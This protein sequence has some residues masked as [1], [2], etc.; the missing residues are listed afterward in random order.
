MCECE[1]GQCPQR[2]VFFPF[3]LWQVDVLRPCWNPLWRFVRYSH[4]AVKLHDQVMDFW[5]AWGIMSGELCWQIVEMGARIPLRGRISDCNLLVVYMVSG[6]QSCI[7]RLWISITGACNFFWQSCT[8]R[9]RI[10]VN[11]VA[12]LIFGAIRRSDGM[13]DW[14][15][16]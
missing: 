16:I 7:P 6:P 3:G 11:G 13:S 8:P 14:T 1:V 15:C 10:S 4:C 5:I 2:C 9:L 12:T